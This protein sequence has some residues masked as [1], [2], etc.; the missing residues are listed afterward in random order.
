[1]KKQT[2]IWI[3]S[4]KA[5]IITLS[6]GNESITEV[7][8]D[9][10][11]KVYHQQ[12]GDSGDFMGTRHINNEKKFDERKK[13]Q[14]EQFLKAVIGKIKDHDE[15][16]IFGPAEMKTKLK[17]K[18]EVGE[19]TLCGKLKSVETADSMTANQMVAHTKKHYGQ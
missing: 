4:S 15:V 3:D 10:D 5:M 16:Y 9:I 1:M 13:Q 11:N 7:K 19:V 17:K 18:I 8:S 6:E 12:E 2:G 14:I